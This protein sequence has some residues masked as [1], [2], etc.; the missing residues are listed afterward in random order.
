MH[1]P[2][3]RV[4]AIWVVALPDKYHHSRSIDR[5]ACVV[6]KLFQ[7]SG[8]DERQFYNRP[9]GIFK[10]L[11]CNIKAISAYIVTRFSRRD[12]AP[13]QRLDAH[14]KFKHLKRLLQIIVGTDFKTLDNIVNLRAG[15]EKKQRN[16]AVNLP[17][18]PTHIE[19]VHAW[20][21]HIGHDDIGA[22]PRELPKTLL[23]V[24][25][26]RHLESE[27]R[28]AETI[29]QRRRL[30]SRPDR[31]ERHRQIFWRQSCNLSR[32]KTSAL[33]DDRQQPRVTLPS[34]GQSQRRLLSE[35]FRFQRFL[36]QPHKLC[37]RRDIIS[38][39]DA[40][41]IFPKRRLGLEETEYPARGSQ[42]LPDIMAD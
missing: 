30:Q 8:F 12:I 34:D 7:Q 14:D 39:Q 10:S 11:C 21:H 3:K 24:G 15:R 17:Y 42:H 18:A 28:D 31:C 19:T 40:G 36:E 33:Q 26:D 35:R 29:P 9:A 1:K 27:W 22:I 4:A 25:G 5:P 38:A 20:H 16:T 37:R 23:A 41:R 2:V 6:N 32:A 13:Q